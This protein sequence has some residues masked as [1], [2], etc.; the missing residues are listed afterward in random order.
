[1]KNDF[2]DISLIIAGNKN[3]NAGCSPLILVGTTPFS[4]NDISLMDSQAQIAEN[5][6][7]KIQHTKEYI[8][9]VLQ[10]FVMQSCDSNRTNGCLYVYLVIKRNKQLACKQSPYDLLIKIYKKFLDSNTN[11]LGSGIYKY[12]EGSYDSQPFKEI[13]DGCS[14]EERTRK[15]FVM[16][17]ESIGIVRCET[18]KKLEELFRDS[19]YSEFANYK[20]I[21]IGRECVPTILVDIPRSHGYAVYLNGNLNGKLTK[22]DEKFYVQ[23]SEPN[24]FQYYDSYSF[25]LN[26]LRRY[27]GQ[28][29]NGK[30]RLDENEEKILCNSGLIDRE[31]EYD[32]VFQYDGNAI[33]DEVY[34]KNNIHIIICN[35]DVTKEFISGKVCIRGNE[36]MHMMHDNSLTLYGFDL[37][38]SCRDRRLVVDVKKKAIDFPPQKPI[39][40]L[41]HAEEPVSQ[42]IK[43]V[44]TNARTGL[45]HV[46]IRVS[47]EGKPQWIVRQSTRLL[48][49]NQDRKYNK[50]YSGVISLDTA[51]LGKNVDIELKIESKGELN[52]LRKSMILREGVN[53]CPLSRM[54]PFHKTDY[55]FLRIGIIIFALLL[56][57]VSGAGIH[58]LWDYYNQPISTTDSTMLIKKDSLQ[59]DRLNNKLRIFNDSNR[60]LEKI[61][62][63]KSDTIKQLKQNTSALKKENYDLRKQIN[64]AKTNDADTHN[65]KSKPAKKDTKSGNKIKK[66]TDDNGNTREYNKVPPR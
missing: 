29:Y 6:S 44:L 8:L 38:L 39:K 36:N 17:G 50:T 20:E 41:P 65:K 30:V 64:E 34:V 49:E 19:Q 62:S 10:T 25:T 9:Y 53:E 1:M 16:S 14:L 58:I 55:R 11:L 23:L 27:G 56:G 26:E 3:L 7:F 2:S 15:Y 66:T 47:E 28:L 24:E 42:Y 54:E 63:L 37:Y 40:N 13:L 22:E 33:A 18:E 5:P 48:A 4:Q 12:K 59:I 60:I 57:G 32:A 35:R 31:I 52:L 45:C 51:W 61:D 46:S 21:E 43:L